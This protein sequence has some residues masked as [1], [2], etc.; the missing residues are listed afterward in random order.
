MIG[1]TVVGGLLLAFYLMFIKDLGGGRSGAWHSP[2]A[3][4]SAA[5]AVAGV[6]LLIGAN[7]RGVSDNITAL[8][9][10]AFEGEGK[11]ASAG[12]RVYQLQQSW[13]LFLSSP[14]VGVGTGRGIV[15]F[16]DEFANRF[17]ETSSAHNA[18]AD[19]AIRWGVVGLVCVTA[20]FAVAFCS[21]RY[22]RSRLSFLPAAALISVLVKSLLEPA[23]DKYRL[24]Y[25]IALCVVALYAS[26]QARLNTGD[27]HGGGGGVRAGG[28]A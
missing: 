26:S 27:G 9:A 21:K 15:Y 28:L 13:D 3:V 22:V 10:G 17:V 19:V 23:F 5:F 12:T 1:T 20:I 24:A 14:V 4:V 7:L 25:V 16:Y 18:V 11:V 2:K 8:I 6:A